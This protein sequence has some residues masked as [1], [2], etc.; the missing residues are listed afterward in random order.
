MFGIEKTSP[1]FLYVITVQEIEFEVGSQV[2]FIIVDL[3]LFLLDVETKT[4]G[5]QA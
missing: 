5:E 2:N 4:S 3:S 1:D